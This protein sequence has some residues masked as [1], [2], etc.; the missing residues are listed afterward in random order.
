MAIK[1]FTRKMV[2]DAIDIENDILAIAK[3]TQDAGA[4]ADI[5]GIIADINATGFPI[6]FTAIF[7]GA[8]EKQGA[9]LVDALQKKIDLDNKILA[10]LPA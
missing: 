8:V 6:P 7:Q 10:L 1:D 2:Q 4:Q 9:A 5:A 3:V